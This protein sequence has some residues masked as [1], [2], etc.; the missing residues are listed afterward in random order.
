MSWFVDYQIPSDLLMFDSANNSDISN[1]V[2]NVKEHVKSVLQVI[3]YKKEWLLKE[4]EQKA[5]IQAKKNFT[6][7]PHPPH[8]HYDGTSAEGEAP[9]MLMECTLL[10]GGGTPQCCMMAMSKASSPLQ[11]M[12]FMAALSAVA[13]SDSISFMKMPN[14]TLWHQC[15]GSL[16]ISKKQQA[17]HSLAEHKAHT[18]ESQDFTIIPWILDSKIEKLD[19]NNSLQSTIIKTG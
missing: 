18:S 17:V 15:S 7:M 1:K 4:V 19:T 9:G 6:G 14:Y 13:T 3:E 8:V 5:D 16:S 12:A 11:A 10:S 2:A